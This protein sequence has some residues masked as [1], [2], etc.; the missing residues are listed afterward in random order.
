LEAGTDG[1]HPIDDID[2]A[3]EEEIEEVEPVEQFDEQEDEA[4]ELVLEEVGVD[5]VE[6]EDDSDCCTVGDMFEVDVEVDVDVETVLTFSFL[7]G[8]SSC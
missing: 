5:V 6:D 7:L 2:I 8:S 4:L 3:A 1:Q